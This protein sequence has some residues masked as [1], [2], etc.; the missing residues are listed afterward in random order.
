MNTRHFSAFALGLML[1][2][3]P[4]ASPAQPH[5]PPTQAT[6]PTP[7][8]SPILPVT[9]TVAPGFK[10]P[11]VRPTSAAIV[12]ITQQP[13]VGIKLMDAVTM[14]LAKNPNLAISA[15]NTR[16]A[17]YQIAAA[18]GAYDVRFNVVPSVTHSVTAPEN[19]FFAGPNFGPITANTQSLNVGVSG[20]LPTGTQYQVGITQ[21]KFDN[22]TIINAFDPW[23]TSTL[24]AS[25]TQPLL[26]NAGPGNETQRQIQLAVIN[27]DATTAATLTSVS[28]TIGQVSDAYWDLVAAWRSVAIQEDALK[29]AVAQQNSNVRLAKHGAAAPIDAVESST[30]V[31]VYQDNVF[32]A[33]QR[34]AQLQNQL[35]SLIADNPGDPIWMAN[36][37]PTTSIEST[38]PALSLNQLMSNAMKY[39]PEL[40]QA[41]AQRRQAGVNLAYAKNQLLPQVDLQ[42]QYQ[43]NGFA[44][45]A[46]PPVGGAFGS[47][48][49][50]PYLGGT[51]SQAYGNIGRFPSYTVGVNISAPLGNH[52][53]KAQYAAAQEQE[54]I[55]TITSSN[56][57]ER[58]LFDV[59]NA[60]Q[61][62]Q[63]AE[64]RLYAARR[65]REA[66]QAV[67]ESELRRFRAGESTTFLVTQRQIE[68]VQNQGRE[69]QAQTDFDKA[70]VALREADGT[71]F[72]A[73]NVNL[74][75]LGEGALK[76]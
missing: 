61:N 16:I 62:F 20:Q 5:S 28:N 18:K 13:F 34:V 29:Q 71:I 51:Y 4:L 21:Q 15:A 22:N 14:A 31:A 2:A 3:V 9:P 27:Q 17:G 41:A 69:L 64:S 50:P 33:L 58:I 37:M 74:S 56:V 67:Y 7:E 44:G 32:S 45:N 8:P 35:K 76:P 42:A 73:S 60:L 12:G 70:V 55:A 66:S 75:T 38:P 57:D 47:A 65:A 6:I 10:A 19:A 43:G 53:A 63:T 11:D 1:V 24:N 40:A 30:Q 68:L 49:P 52:T 39:R 72:A 36:L 25:I 46:L 23:Y 59:R 48:T 26:K 54:R